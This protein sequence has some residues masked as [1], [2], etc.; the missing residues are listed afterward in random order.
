MYKKKES[1]AI[2][3]ICVRCE[4]NPQKRKKDKYQALCSS[5]DHALWSAGA[6]KRYRDKRYRPY[7]TVHQKQLICSSCSFQAVHLCQMDIDHIDGDGTN[8][9]A[10]NLH[11]L[12]A[13]CHRLKT[14]LNRDWL[15]PTQKGALNGR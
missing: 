1:T 9:V 15:S 14:Q 5:C 13:N 7:T 10:E 4:K 8:D 2:R 6:R 12:C 3:G 11:T